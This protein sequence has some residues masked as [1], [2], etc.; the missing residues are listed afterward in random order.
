MIIHISAVN[1]LSVE[2]NQLL[3]RLSTCG[4]FA[5]IPASYGVGPFAVAY[6][7]KLT[8]SVCNHGA[9]FPCIVNE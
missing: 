9:D 6:E 4:I 3:E 7:L 8:F 1:K 2:F 5:D